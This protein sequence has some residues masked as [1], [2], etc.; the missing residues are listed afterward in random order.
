MEDVD[1][2]DTI[3]GGYSLEWG[4]M[5]GYSVAEI[6]SILHTF[7]GT[8]SSRLHYARLALRKL[9]KEDFE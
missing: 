8:V 1:D 9:L 7:Q 2:P 5:E 3:G 4:I 6:A